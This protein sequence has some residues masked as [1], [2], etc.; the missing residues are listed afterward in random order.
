MANR[1]LNYVINVLQ[2]MIKTKLP[3][4]YSTRRPGTRSHEKQQNY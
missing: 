3:C 2:E 1:E 4:N